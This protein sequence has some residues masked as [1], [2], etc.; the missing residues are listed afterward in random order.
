MVH[1]FPAIYATHQEC[2]RR[3]SVMERI[4][5]VAATE[6]TVAFVECDLRDRKKLNEVFVEHKPQQVI[7]FAGLKA[8]GE[9]KLI[10]LHYY[11]NNISGT[12]V[13][14]ETM[15]KHKCMDLVFSS[16]CT[17][18]GESKPPLSEEAPIGSGV[19]NAYGRT[20]FMIEEILRDMSRAC[21]LKGSE[22]E[23]SGTWRFAIL[24]YF[25]PVGAHP[26][27]LLGE[28]PM[29]KPNCLMP[30]VLQVL[31]GRRKELTVFG[32]DYPTRDGTCIRDYIHVMDVAKGH[33][34]A[35]Q[36]LDKQPASSNVCEAFNFGTGKGTTVLELVAGLEKASGKT[37]S[38]VMG[39]RRP[40]DLPETYCDPA[41][42]LE[43]LGWACEYDLDAMCKHAWDWQSKN[44]Y[45]YRTEE[46][47]KK[48]EEDKK[49]AGAGAA[50]T[51]STS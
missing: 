8:V 47:V 44:P 32:S 23:A 30:Y 22:H 19:T 18:Y 16:S 35:L 29:G 1:Y 2:A 6:G 12:I 27:G 31:V 36:W 45:G 20:K 3:K 33:I 49:A 26:S 37:V 7:H 46:E 13:L 17:V 39:P 38:K 21:E 9:S 11:D 42:A 43:Q 15:A 34:D 25:N 24:R 4:S 14:L 5:T 41:K 40:G 28:D 10:P 48:E 51:G 50:A